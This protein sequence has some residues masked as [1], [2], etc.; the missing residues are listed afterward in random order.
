MKNYKFKFEKIT[1]LLL[2]IIIVM[3]GFSIQQTNAT[4]FYNNGLRYKRNI[5]TIYI[6]KTIYK[7]KMTLFIG[8]ES[9]IMID[10][11]L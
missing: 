4:K 2:I 5:E 7:Y 3:S 6:G 9:K 1:L 11:V 10:K 8:N